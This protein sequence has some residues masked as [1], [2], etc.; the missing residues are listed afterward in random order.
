MAIFLDNTE[1]YFSDGTVFT[2][3]TGQFKSDASGANDANRA[4]EYIHADDFVRA[5]PCL[6]KAAEKGDVRSMYLLGGAYV[7]GKGV[8]TDWIETK[9]WLE[10]AI[11]HGCDNDDVKNLL[12]GIN[13]TLNS[14]KE[15]DSRAK[16]K[17]KKEFPFLKKL[18]EE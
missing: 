4:I 14:Y 10:K 6:K 15:A 16:R 7:L 3:N 17:L 5:I 12:A 13:N 2:G 9:Y 18:A 8:E 11:S 1:K